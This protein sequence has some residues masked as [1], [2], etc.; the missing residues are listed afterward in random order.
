VLI[1]PRLEI[2]DEQQVVDVILKALSESSPMADAA[3]T[4]WKQMQTIRVQRA[5]PMVTARG[6]LLPLHIERHLK[7]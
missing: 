6:K 2:A 3:R 5:E 4:V 1:H 7:S